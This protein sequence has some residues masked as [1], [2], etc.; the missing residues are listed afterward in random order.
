VRIIG[1]GTGPPGSK[2]KLLRRLMRTALRADVAG[3]SLPPFFLPLLPFEP[4]D[5]APAPGTRAGYS[6]GAI[7][8]VAQVRQIFRG[9]CSECRAGGAQNVAW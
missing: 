3:A 8:H 9:W 6:V 5:D 1:S 7:Q 4:P 2:Y